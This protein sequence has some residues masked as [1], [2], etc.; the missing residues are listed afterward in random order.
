MIPIKLMSRWFMAI[1]LVSVTLFSCKREPIN[2]IV[3]D[4]EYEVIH[5]NMQYYDF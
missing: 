1:L 5:I 2:T 3:E 4:D